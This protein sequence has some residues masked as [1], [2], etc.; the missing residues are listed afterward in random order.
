MFNGG[1]NTGEVLRETAKRI[2]VR[3]TTSTQIT[4]ENWFTKVNKPA[5]RLISRRH[6]LGPGDVTLPANAG[7]IETDAPGIVP[8]FGVLP[9]DVIGPDGTNYGPHAKRD[10]E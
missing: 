7:F 6:T 9:G 1:L 5:G 4:R 8:D 3:F 2:L 10:D